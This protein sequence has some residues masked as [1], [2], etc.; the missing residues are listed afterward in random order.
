[1]HEE[2]RRVPGR[3]AYTNCQARIEEIAR[4]G[5]LAKRGSALCE[6]LQRGRRGLQGPVGSFALRAALRCC[7]SWFLRF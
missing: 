3:G 2:S 7:S 1:M 6:T 5:L 4:E